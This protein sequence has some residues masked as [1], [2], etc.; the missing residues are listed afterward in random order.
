[1]RSRVMHRLPGRVRVEIPAL[2]RIPI[3]NRDMAQMLIKAIPEPQG[4][5]R[6]ETS[7]ITGNVL[8][9]YDHH[10]TTEAHL[11]KQIDSLVN[12]VVKYRDKMARVNAENLPR[13]HA[14]LQE[15]LSNYGSAS[16]T[17]LKEVVIPDDVWS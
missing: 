5:K 9:E 8:L 14:R 2:R 1:M 15:L 6:L 3:E 12:L 16:H 17:A 13:V 4:V 7:F 11:L 10:V